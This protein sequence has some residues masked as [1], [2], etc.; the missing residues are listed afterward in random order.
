[1]RSMRADF[2]SKPTPGGSGKPTVP[3]SICLSSLKPPN[4]A[5]ISG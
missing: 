2:A 4:G 5:N 3:F 1:M